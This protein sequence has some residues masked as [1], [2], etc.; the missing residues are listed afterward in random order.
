MALLACLSSRPL[1]AYVP[2]SGPSG[3]ARVRSGPQVVCSLLLSALSL[4]LCVIAL[5]YGFVSRFKG[6]FSAVYGVCVG[7]CCLDALRGLCGFC[8]RE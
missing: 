5:E 4:C 1:V 2:D 6:V 7:L 3:P 8:T